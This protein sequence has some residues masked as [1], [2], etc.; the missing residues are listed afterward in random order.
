MEAAAAGKA[1]AF[2]HAIGLSSIIL[3][4][5]LEVVI[6]ALRR[7]DDFFASFGNYIVD[8]KSFHTF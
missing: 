4:E 5:D 7:E 2:P 3:K 1:L 6:K 8:A